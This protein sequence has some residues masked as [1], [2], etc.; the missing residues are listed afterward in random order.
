MFRSSTIGLAFHCFHGDL[1]V[2]AYPN[3]LKNLNSPT[4][5]IF[6]VSKLPSVPTVGAFK[7]C[8]NDSTPLSRFCRPWRQWRQFSFCT[9]A[10]D[11]SFGAKG[12]PIQMIVFVFWIRS[13][14]KHPDD[15]YFWREKG[16]QAMRAA[17]N[18][19]SFRSIIAMDYF[20][21]MAL[22]RLD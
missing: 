17:I 9:D 16:R 5:P 3:S 6:F 19:G 20:K 4:S 21:A 10:T 22:I 8:W 7:Y 13:L 11:D 18:T 14:T 2:S 1:P 15:R 12:L